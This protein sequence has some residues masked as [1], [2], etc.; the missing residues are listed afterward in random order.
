VKT[1]YKPVE[2]G[3]RRWLERTAD[4]VHFRAVRDCFEQRVLPA[5]RAREVGFMLYGFAGMR[6]SQEGRDYLRTLS[7][8]EKYAA[9]R[10]APAT[11]CLLLCARRLSGEDIPMEQILTRYEQVTGRSEIKEVQDAVFLLVRMEKSSREETRE[12]LREK[13]RPA[14]TGGEAGLVALLNCLNSYYPFDRNRDRQRE[15]LPSERI[16]EMARQ[17][18]GLDEKTFTFARRPSNQLVTALLSYV[19][20]DITR[21]NRAMYTPLLQALRKTPGRIRAERLLVSVYAD[22]I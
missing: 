14:V 19:D 8:Q 7:G 20:G 15:L 21:E 2:P 6:G 9:L 17:V 1:H 4:P 11:D 13:L 10:Q 18:T 3:W 22:D 5:G 16:L 12:Y